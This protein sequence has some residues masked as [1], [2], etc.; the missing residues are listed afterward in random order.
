MG[1]ALSKG[2]RCPV[3][4]KR[5]SSKCSKKRVASSGY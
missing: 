3:C 4:G 2:A 1:G 5:H